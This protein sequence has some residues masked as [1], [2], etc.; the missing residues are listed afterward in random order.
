MYFFKGTLET[1]KNVQHL[2]RHTLP[3][4]VRMSKDGG[5]HNYVAYIAPRGKQCL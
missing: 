1:V 5:C 4:P 3:D 2:I